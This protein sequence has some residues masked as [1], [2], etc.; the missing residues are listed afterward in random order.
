MQAMVVTR[1]RMNCQ[2]RGLANLHRIAYG[3]AGDPADYDTCVQERL[4]EIWDEALAQ[5]E[6]RSGQCRPGRAGKARSELTPRR[7]RE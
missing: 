2:G 7:Q 6:Q 1:A 5:L 3:T 4:D